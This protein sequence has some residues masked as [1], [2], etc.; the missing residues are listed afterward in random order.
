MVSNNN[1]RHENMK[2]KI[3]VDM[4]N[5]AFEDDPKDEL[6]VILRKA[7]DDNFRFHK[8]YD[9]NG[10]MVGTLVIEEG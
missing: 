2:C 10:N 6:A 8:L 9:V 4:D 3:E 5:A 7:I 1:R